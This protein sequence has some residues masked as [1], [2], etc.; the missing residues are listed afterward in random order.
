MIATLA[1][2]GRVVVA[3]DTLGDAGRPARRRFTVDGAGPAAVAAGAGEHHRPAARGRRAGDRLGRRRQP[4]PGAAGHDPLAAAPRIGDPMSDAVRRGPG[5][6]LAGP[7]CGDAVRRI[8]A[9]PSLG[10]AGRRSLA[11]GRAIVAAPP[12]VALLAAALSVPPSWPVRR[13]ASACSRA[14]AGSAIVPAAAWWALA[15]R[16]G[17]RR[18]RRPTLLRVGLLAAR[19]LPRPTR[20]RRSPPCCRT[21]AWSPAGCCARWVGRVADR[22]GGRACGVGAGRPG[23][24]SAACRP[25]GR[26]SARSSARSSRRG[27]PACSPGSCAAR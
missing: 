16:H 3:V 1:R 22:A 5:A 7:D 20:R 4:R 8:G 21:T 19:A 24:W 26:W 12:L 23:R 17:R 25:P 6:A 27:W 18:R 10:P 14:P 15:G 13:G 11:A 2:A 9:V